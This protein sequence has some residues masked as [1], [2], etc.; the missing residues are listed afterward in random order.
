MSQSITRNK[1]GS[2]LF[3]GLS[4]QQRLPLLICV[5]LLCVVIAFSWTSYVGVKNAAFDMSKDRLRTLSEQVSS[6]LSQSAQITLAGTRAAAA[7]PKLK[8]YLLSGNTQ[9]D[10]GVLSVLNKL[11]SDSTWVRAELL[12]ANRKQLISS[13]LPG[14]DLRVKDD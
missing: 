7:N 6:L 14:I 9:P 12:D 5:L 3:R 4:I 11:R 13:E 8:Q 10:T 1:S 2:P